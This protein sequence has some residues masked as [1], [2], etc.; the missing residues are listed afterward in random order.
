MYEICGKVKEAEKA[1]FFNCIFC[2]A[3]KTRSEVTV[4]PRGRRGAGREECDPRLEGS[5]QQHPSAL[6]AVCMAFLWEAACQ[7][8]PATGACSWWG[9]A[10]PRGHGACLLPTRADAQSHCMGLFAGTTHC[11]PSGASPLAP[12]VPVKKSILLQA[13]SRVFYSLA[14]IPFPDLSDP[15][16]PPHNASFCTRFNCLARLGAFMQLPPRQ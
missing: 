13:P 5:A 15:S 16:L 2:H 14:S 8:L 12:R 6:P 1:L 9:Q 11:I 4:T 10:A 3:E 7:E